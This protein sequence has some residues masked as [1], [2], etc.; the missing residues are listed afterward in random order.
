MQARFSK[1]LRLFALIGGALTALA[2]GAEQVYR[3][4]DDNGITHFSQ[5][6]PPPG[7]S[8]LSVNEIPASQPPAVD[9]AADYWSITNQVQ[10][11]EASRVALEQ[12]RIEQK[13]LRIEMAE[14]QRRQAEAAQ[15]YAEPY[16]R[17]LIYPAYGYRYSYYPH[18]YPRVGHGFRPRHALHHGH[19]PFGHHP[20]RTHG[21]VVRP[22]KRHKDWAPNR[23]SRRMLAR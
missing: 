17:T 18:V 22:A 11:L 1:S 5:Q 4:V 7:V 6:P 16:E 20:K 19:Q 14:A 13:K 2:A 23:V 21:R 3:W 8:G 10:R 9:P 15:D 12:R